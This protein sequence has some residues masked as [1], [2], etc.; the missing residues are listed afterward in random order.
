MLSDMTPQPAPSPAQLARKKPTPGP[1]AAAKAPAAQPA[2][3]N[4]AQWGRVEADG[5]AWVRTGDGERRISQYKAGTPE[6]GLA[7]FG[8]RFDDL[9]TEV[10]L[11]E[12]RLRLHPEDA[13]AIRTQ[14]KEV[15]AQLD[16]AAVIGDLDSLDTRLVGIIADTDTAQAQ[17]AQEKQRRRAEA[18]AAKEKLAAEAE[19]IAANSTEWK[20]AGDRIHAILEEWKTIHG[21]DRK[22][23]DKLW[24]RYS[25]ARDSFNRRRGSHFAD[26]DRARAQAKRAKEELVERAQ[27]LQDSTDW[28]ETA[29]AFR[30]LMKEW[31]TIGRAPREADD[32]LWEQFRGAQ[33]HFFDART[34]ANN[35]RDREYADN[36]AAKDA[37]L[38]EYRPL[39]KPEENLEAARDKLAELQEKWEQIGYVPRGKVREYEDKIASLERSVKEAAESKWRRTDPAAQARA[40]QFQA[41]VDEFTAQAEQAEA[42][43]NAKQAEKLR[44]QAAQW[45]E[46][47]NTAAQAVENR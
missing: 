43:G 17:V 29:R 19:E 8:A 44:A 21:V 36:A 16:T 14:A 5:T 27:A 23:D 33:D 38:D 18:I 13:E 9:S 46:W 11:L 37:L 7:H 35:A 34:A 26:L 22:T 2:P 39:I 45:A 3:N 41:K 40:A 47:A 30:D 25:R 20:A 10:S 31:K 24:K 6:E 32:A 12:S 42:K 15:R 1:K 4:P 28:G